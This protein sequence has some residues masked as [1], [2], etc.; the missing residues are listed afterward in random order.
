MVKRNF[1]KVGFKPRVSLELY[2]SAN[3]SFADNKGKKVT[4][5]YKSPDISQVAIKFSFKPG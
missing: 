2:K 3:I 4:S 1:E 5:L